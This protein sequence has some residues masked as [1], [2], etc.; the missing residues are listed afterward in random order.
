MRGWVGG[1]LIKCSGRTAGQVSRRA[2]I[3]QPQLSFVLQQAGQQRRCTSGQEAA[4]SER[5]GT[6]DMYCNCIKL[7]CTHYDVVPPSIAVPVGEVGADPVLHLHQPA[8]RGVG[9]GW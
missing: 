2:A 4:R 7:Y 8:V 9:V 5:Y 3:S 1:C 6:T